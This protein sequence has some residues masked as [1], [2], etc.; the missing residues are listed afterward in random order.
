[1]CS[2]GIVLTEALTPSQVKYRS[3][4]FGWVG[5]IA[6]MTDILAVFKSTGV[7]TI[8][9]AKK[10]QVLLGSIGKGSTLSIQPKLVN[11]LLGTQFKIIGGYAGGNEVNIAMERGEV[12][13]RTNQWESWKSQRPEWVRDGSL[14]YLLQFGPKLS[15]FPDVPSLRELVVKP[16]DLLL[17]D[18]LEVLQYVGRS[19]FTTPGVPADRLAV[20][21][22]AFDET[23]KDPEFIARLKEA[24][25]ELLPRRG[26]ETQSYIT[27]AMSNAPEAARKI[28]QIADAN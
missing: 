14:S 20:L 9:D 7:A 16:E 11:A 17:V 6:T 15:D 19:V 23:M 13:G 18:L 12:S 22:R 5:T 3:S 1:M 10:V 24:Q 26:E 8:N 28:N 27:K 21:R 25:L 4:D 2:A